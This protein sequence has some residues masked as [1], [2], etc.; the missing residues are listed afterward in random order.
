LAAAQPA[1]LVDELE[2]DMGAADEPFTLFCKRLSVQSV[3]DL[4]QIPF[5]WNRPPGPAPS[6]T[7][8][9]SKNFQ[10]F[11]PRLPKPSENRRFLSD[12][13]RKFQEKD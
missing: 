1:A 8:K 3:S 5:G 12:S 13:R 9:A 2:L 11:P 4:E 6:I 7:L 10:K